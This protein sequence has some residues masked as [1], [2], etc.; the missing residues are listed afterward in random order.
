MDDPLYLECGE[1]ETGHW[2]D[3]CKLPSRIWI[4]FNSMNSEGVG[5]ISHLM[6]CPDCAERNKTTD[7]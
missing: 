2:C 7:D 4:P 5:E 1:P 3:E 6:I